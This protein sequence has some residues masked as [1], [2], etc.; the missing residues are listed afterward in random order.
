[1]PPMPP[2]I[3]FSYVLEDHRP[4][5]LSESGGKPASARAVALSEGMKGESLHLP[6]FGGKCS[7]TPVH[8]FLQ[9]VRGGVWEDGI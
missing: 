9:M 7:Q 1:M 6:L 3:Y 5:D 4:C 8:E 2:W